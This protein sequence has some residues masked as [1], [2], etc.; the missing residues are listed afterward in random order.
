MWPSRELLLSAKR[1]ARHS[2][3]AGDTRKGN[4]IDGARESV[5]GTTVW[6]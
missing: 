1:A 4:G 3:G 6:A 5:P 2:A